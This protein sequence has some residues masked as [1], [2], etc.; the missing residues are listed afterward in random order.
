[1]DIR[2]P[3]EPTA[4][5]KPSP[6][7][8]GISGLQNPPL[9]MIAKSGLI[10]LTNVAGSNASLNQSIS[11]TSETDVTGSEFNLVLSKTTDVLVLA[12]MSAYLV[13]T[14]PTDTAH[15]QMRMRETPTGVLKSIYWNSGSTSMRTSTGHYFADF[16][17]G[18]R[19]FKLTAQLNTVTGSPTATIFEF[20][21]TAIAL[22]PT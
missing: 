11:G 14:P 15:L 5:I 19:T 4:P 12:T 8:T 9:E 2:F 21:Y 18:T 22:S 1:M 7:P 16:S 20:R 10:N 3:G 17:A 6:L 13:E